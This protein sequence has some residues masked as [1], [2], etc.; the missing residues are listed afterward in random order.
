M[1]PVQAAD[2]ASEIATRADFSIVRYAQCWEDADTLLSAL[3]V[4]P[5]D[6]CFSVGSGGENSLSLL[7]KA[8]SKV[9][10]FDISPAQTAFV[11]LKA[12]GFSTLSHPELL[13]FVG[14]RPSNRRL[15][16]Y[17]RVRPRL[18]DTA[19]SYWDAHPH[20]IENRLV[21]A[22]RFEHYFELFRRWVLPLTHSRATRAALLAPR[23]P[24][25]RREF[26]ETRWNNW[27]WRALFKLFFSRFVM[28]RV[29]RDPQFFTYVEDEVAKPMFVRT[30]H[31]LSALDASRNA[32]LQ[33]IIAGEFLTALPHAWRAENF[34]A[35]RGNIDRLEIRLAS[36]KSFLETAADR[37]IDRFNLSDIFEYIPLE[38]SDRLFTEI[39]RCARP[40]GR[41][42]YWNTEATRRSPR[43]L[44]ERVRLL[45]DLSRR[46]HS[47]TMTFF[48]KALYVEQVL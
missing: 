15:D 30:G 39:V 34:D 17:Q 46:L 29:G 42:A 13:E 28:G 26:Y 19:R 7:S 1:N 6:V 37:S 32:Y 5:G 43:E 8:P 41:L 23:P 24:L 47:E 27:R 21:N 16:L 35:I 36:A 10:A 11:E 31:A 3:D 12:A 22:G 38:A 45:D 40:G 25:E 18:S 48:Y 20:T 14:I 2:A 4:Q 9:I 44:A 33:W